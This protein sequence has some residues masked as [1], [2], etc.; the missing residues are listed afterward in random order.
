[1]CQAGLRGNELDTEMSY[2]SVVQQVPCWELGLLG[3]CLAPRLPA[4][5]PVWKARGPC[6]MKGGWPREAGV[7]VF[8]CPLPPWHGGRLQALMWQPERHPGVCACARVC[9]LVHATHAECSRF[10]APMHFKPTWTRP[11]AHRQVQT[12]WELRDLCGRFLFSCLHGE[13]GSVCALGG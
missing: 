2:L 5:C 12:G 4:W 10:R 8:T 6:E 7:G 13:P 3:S 1:M 11:E 9:T